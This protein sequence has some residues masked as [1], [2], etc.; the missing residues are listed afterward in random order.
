[1]TAPARADASGPLGP[2]GGSASSPQSLQAR[3]T[4]APA[5][6][7][8]PTAQDLVA[9]AVARWR[10]VLAARAG[11]S[12]LTDVDRLGDARLDLTAA[13]PS[14]LAQLFA[15]RPTR[16]SNLVR[17]G[18][19]L[20]AARRRARAVAALADDHAQRY[21]IASA[22]VAIGV[23]TWTE[24]PADGEAPDGDEPRTVRA[25]VLLRPVTIVAR[26]RGEADHELSLEP[27]LEVN[28]LLA[29]AL[30]ARGA[31][32][33][34]HALARAAFTA[35]GF[36]PE[37]VL[38][39][40][41][42]LGSAVL[43]GFTLEDRLLVGTFVHPEQVLVDDLDAQAASLAEHEVIR[44]LAGHERSVAAL[45]HPL[46]ERVRGDR[47]LDAERGVGDLDPRQTDVLDAVAAGHH[48][49]VD[50]PPG[51]DAVGTLAALVA[52]A[53]AAGRTVLYVPGHRRAADAL[54]D[55]LAEL[56]LDSVV[57]DG[58][59]RAGQT[60]RTEQRLLSAMTVEPVPI[61]TDQVAVVQRELL[62]RRRRLHG[63]VDGLHTPREPWGASAYDALQALA[64]LTSARPAPRTTVR[65]SPAVAESLDRERRA[66][67]AA[68]LV[69]LAGL[70]A[71]SR[72]AAAS[73]WSGAR[74][75]S[76]ADA[77]ATLARLVRLQEELLPTV[78]RQAAEVAEVTGL[79][80]ATTPAAWAE[81]LRMLDGV[82]ASLDVFLPIV[83]ERSA[84]DLVA[85]TA[86]KE[87]RE[88]RGIDMPAGVRRRLRKQARDMVRPG[89]PVADLHAALAQVQAQREVWQAHCPGGGWPR[90][91]AGLAEHQATARALAE[92]LHAVGATLEGTAEGGALDAL[93]FDELA[94]RLARLRADASTLEILPERTALLDS[95]TRRG[96]GDLVRDLAERQVAATQVSAELELAWWSTA[97]EQVLAQ[98]P[99]LA[100]YDGAALTRLVAEFRV[101][102][103]RYLADRARLALAAT[104][105]ELRRR[106]RAGEDETQALFAELVEHRFA[107]LRQAVERY[108]TVTRHLRPCLVA[109]PVL[110][111]H[112]LPARRQEDLVVLDA[113][114]D[115]P[116]EV[117]VAAVARA[118]QVVVVGDTRAAAGSALAALAAVLPTVTL[119]GDV[120]GR[121]PRLRAFLR[122]HGY[123]D[124]LES[125]PVPVD[126]P[127]LALHVVDGTGMPGPSG[128]VES[129]DAEVAQVV[130]LV[131]DH[132]LSRPHESLAVVTPSPG[133]AARVRDA[134]LSEVRSS[135]A[136]EQFFRP[137]HPEPFVV[138]EV[139]QDACPPRDAVVWSTGFGR[140]PH[141]RVLHR[142]GVLSEDG[143]DV[144]LLAA[145]GSARRRL[146]V[147]GCF[148]A[149]DLDDERLKAPGARLLRD[150]LRTAAEPP[151][152]AHAAGPPEPS[153]DPDRL[154]LDLA[155]RLWRRGLTVT[156][157]HGVDGD[158]R[159]PLVVGHPD[160]P[161]EHLVAVLTDDDAYVGEPSVR[162]RDR[163]LP[164]RLE[165]LGWTVVQVWSAAAFLDPVG[166]AEAIA[167]V[168]IET[169]GRRLAARAAARQVGIPARRAPRVPT[170]PAPQEAADPATSPDSTAP[171]G[172][173]EPAGVV[174]APGTVEPD[175]P[176]QPGG[177][178]EPDGSGEVATGA[179]GDVP[180][181]V[182]TVPQQRR[183]GAP[184]PQVETLELG[185]I[186][187]PDAVPAPRGPRPDVPRGL[188]IQA[189][190]DDQLD[191]VVA[192]LL[193]DGTPRSD[194]ELAEAVR[195]ELGLTRRGARVDAVVEAAVRRAR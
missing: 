189:Y 24:R 99:A 72:E 100:G 51:S 87:W 171:E 25:P 108:P 56:G 3:Q 47:P 60:D 48:L 82:R 16:L 20:A 41:R 57:L 119:T 116:L 50:T 181:V 26:G 168:T 109:S 10:A 76:V 2:E 88:E 179:A 117:A 182:A 45:A 146:T 95:L 33:D 121:D 42:A 115:V 195:A 138:V 142:F 177:A 148:G 184:V 71:F 73:P 131:V 191:E 161:G 132:A 143:G 96:L 85:A 1:M 8:V 69:R 125:L 152:A 98:D 156:L 21:G 186:L 66:Q 113:A 4:P 68:D 55:R 97:F 128:V 124:A 35:S 120:S 5:P 129:T 11:E 81:Q 127:G 140:T 112:L 105:E 114:D 134:V 49:V 34:A 122:D 13:H 141:G 135:P 190:T 40:L 139:G 53:T 70:G 9:D 164:E 37:P 157:D 155:E 180:R 89:R 167:Q 103:R 110:V 61:R 133:H 93:T 28:P 38:D 106:L 188:P 65:L 101:L 158:L 166:E 63:Y 30:R 75:V 12:A 18:A 126:E 111:P 22:F 83:F 176:D 194:A 59:A 94:A 92:E 78:A 15:G 183:P 174:E 149:D 192:W 27:S 160:L 7:P 118:R 52:E 150:L 172:T 14:G 80:P 162:V 173:A 144:R 130:D 19:A 147:V 151:A 185:R 31:L 39:R 6:V 153:A 17:E 86:E 145:V 169:C 44:A 187:G 58:A 175:Q 74:V 62:D 77:R 32:L 193:A 67:A 23:A 163:Q 104:R 90:V 136:L 54:L 170:T 154:V 29:A 165:R 178:G 43:D 64:R 102:D 107:G 123:G 79:V 36:D 84:A 159:I 46:P 137:D 91:P